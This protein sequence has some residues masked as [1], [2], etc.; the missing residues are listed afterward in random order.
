MASMCGDNKQTELCM[1]VYL[2]G[3]HTPE[4]AVHVPAAVQLVLGLPLKPALHEAV[5]TEPT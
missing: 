4:V 3:A 1:P 5:Q 2:L